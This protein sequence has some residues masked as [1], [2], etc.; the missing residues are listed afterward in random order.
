MSRRLPLSSPDLPAADILAVRLACL[1]PG[2]RA[3]LDAVIAA[4]RPVRACE[5]TR[6]LGRWQAQASQRVVVRLWVHDLLMRVSRARRAP[7]YVPAPGVVEVAAR[8]LSATCRGGLRVDPGVGC[9]VLG[10]A[11]AMAAGRVQPDCRAIHEEIGVCQETCQRWARRL[12]AMGLWPD[13]PGLQRRERL[14]PHR[15][16]VRVRP[17]VVGLKRDGRGRFMAVGAGLMEVRS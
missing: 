8:Y 2:Q 13:G 5:V 7:R 11:R 4:G 14:C 12:R 10:A 16:R 15:E 17:P 3:V 1:A 6:G 9:A